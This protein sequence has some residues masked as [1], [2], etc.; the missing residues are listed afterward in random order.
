MSPA[1]LRLSSAFSRD[2]FRSNQG[3]LSDRVTQ[4]QLQGWL[5]TLS[6]DI[7]MI[8]ST[9]GCQQM[10]AKEEPDVWVV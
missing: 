1:S 7:M 4:L 8:L 9:A 2:G 6:Q 10:N 3:R 5:W